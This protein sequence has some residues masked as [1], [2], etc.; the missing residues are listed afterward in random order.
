MDLWGPSCNRL[1]RWGRTQ[2]GN[3]YEDSRKVRKHLWA[4]DLTS[5]NGTNNELSGSHLSIHTCTQSPLHLPRCPSEPIVVLWP[6]ILLFSTLFMTNGSS[7]LLILC[8]C[9]RDHPLAVPR[10]LRCSAQVFLTTSYMILL[11]LRIWS[12]QLWKSHPGMYTVFLL[13]F[14]SQ[15]IVFSI[16]SLFFQSAP[17]TATG[18]VL[19]NF[20]EGLGLWDR[21]TIQ[22][23]DEVTTVHTNGTWCLWPTFLLS[24]STS[25]WGPCWSSIALG[26]SFLKASLQ[27]PPFLWILS[28]FP[29]ACEW[30]F[31]CILMCCAE[32]PTFSYFIVTQPDTARGRSAGPILSSKSP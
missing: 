30:R 28:L 2:L 6:L 14:K 24:A 7:P 11:P 31:Y 21:S 12:V 32:K 23:S 22:H 18:S 25:S 3:Y 9:L 5:E 4:S 13:V 8:V 20:T 29:V 17:N 16:L 19:Y 26:I 27:L 10:I 15:R 1:C